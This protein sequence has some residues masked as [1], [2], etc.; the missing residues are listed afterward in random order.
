VCKH[1]TQPFAANLISKETNMMKKKI[2]LF[3]LLLNIAGLIDACECPPERYFDYTALTIESKVFV[4]SDQDLLLHVNPQDIY[5]LTENSGNFK[6]GFGMECYATSVCDKG[7]DGE[8][9]PLTGISVV[10][11]SDFDS[12]HPAGSSLNDLIKVY[13]T[14]AQDETSLVLL[15]QH[16][17]S[18]I[19]PYYL[20]IEARPTILNS[21][22][23]T[24]SFT[25]SNNETASGSSSQITWE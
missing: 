21:H 15:S 4:E 23:F 17:I 18:D 22:T 2:L 14:D 19:N 6:L 10:S 5:Y 25:K 24:V 8:K 1:L 12:A 11:N 20:F 13:Y 16:L 7:Y 9:Y 3:L